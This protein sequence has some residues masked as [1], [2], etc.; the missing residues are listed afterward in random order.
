M[1]LNCACG[2]RGTCVVLLARESTSDPFAL[3][4]RFRPPP[5]WSVE[6]KQHVLIDVQCPK[7][8]KAMVRA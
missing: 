3:V 8:D 4:F 5:G 7:C 1:L 6:H 2:A